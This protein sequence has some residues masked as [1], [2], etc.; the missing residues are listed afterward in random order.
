MGFRTVLA[1]ILLF[2][3][4]SSHSVAQAQVDG[5]PFVPVPIPGLEFNP[6]IDVA[7]VRS[8]V[9]NS[10]IW[11]YLPSFS[12]EFLFGDASPIIYLRVLRITAQ[13]GTN[14]G[15]VSCIRC[16]MHDNHACKYRKCRE[17]HVGRFDGQFQKCKCTVL[18][19]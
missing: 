8:N 7:D 3:A 17:K 1:T 5:N 16:V 10:A 15:L 4:A 2:L 14:F 19:K 11:A 9:V 13:F 6:D 12:P 18:G